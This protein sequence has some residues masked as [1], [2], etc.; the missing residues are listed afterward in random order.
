VNSRSD[1]PRL[2]LIYVVSIAVA[3]LVY[4]GSFWVDIYHDFDVL[5]FR[6][7][8]LLVLSGLALVS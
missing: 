5:F 8:G 3:S 1:L 6:S 7:M 2:I 4:V